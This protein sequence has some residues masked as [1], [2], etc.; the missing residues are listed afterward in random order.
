MADMGINKPALRALIGVILLLPAVAFG[1]A[2]VQRTVEGRAV[3]LV[4][5]TGFCVLDV[6]S[7][8]G[9]EWYAFQE[10][11][12]E[13]RGAV[14][15]TYASCAEV[16]KRKADPEFQIQSHGA[17]VTIY[18]FGASAAVPPGITRQQTVSYISSTI[19]RLAEK[20]GDDLNARLRQVDL[21][22]QLQVNDL[23]IGYLD[24]DRDAVY[25]GMVSWFHR[26]ASRTRTIGVGG[27]T[28]VAGLVLSTNLYADE[29]PEVTFGGL[30]ERQRKVMQEL[31]AKNP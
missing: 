27:F 22:K 9:K 18:P 15:L 26:G 28:Q 8:M 5:P 25:A 16:E 21:D 6:D 14:V 19:P 10:K 2:T 13:G 24:E 17:Y 3:N 1:Q 7:V 29:A 20:V 23:T 11:L 31:V 12:I 4:I 30:L